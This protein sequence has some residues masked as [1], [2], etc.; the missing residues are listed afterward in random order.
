MGCYTAGEGA[1]HHAGCQCNEDRWKSDLARERARAERAERE[2]DEAWADGI[3]QGASII[4]AE[5]AQREPRTL[6]EVAKT[7]DGVADYCP[8]QVRTRAMRAE[9]DLARLRDA[10]TAVCR[11]RI[12]AVS[13]ELEGSEW[14]HSR[15]SDSLLDAL[16]AALGGRDE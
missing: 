5:A 14:K 1:T 8:G 11:G 6:S 12:P 15:V 13:A 3:R 16:R 10:A 7:L 4:R 9:A 2:R